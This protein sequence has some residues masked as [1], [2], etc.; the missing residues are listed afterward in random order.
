[1]KYNG[2]YITNNAAVFTMS[3]RSKLFFFIFGTYL[4]ELSLFCFCAFFYSVRFKCPHIGSRIKV[5]NHS[6]LLQ[7]VCGSD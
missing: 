4:Y 2:T 3:V 1:M 5:I 7:H 6:Q